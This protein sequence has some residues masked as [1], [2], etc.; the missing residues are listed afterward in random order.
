MNNMGGSRPWYK[1]GVVWVIIVVIVLVA[2]YFLFHGG[3]SSSTSNT[4]T[5]T[6]QTSGNTQTVST[7][8]QAG[9]VSVVGKLAC[10]PLKSGATPTA[11]QCLL[12]L[13]GNDGKFYALDTTK[14]ASTDNNITPDSTVVAVGTFTAS[15]PNNTESG[16][17]KYDG[18]LAVR[19]MAVNK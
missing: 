17:Y 5:N 7:T 13:Q 12:G 6:S 11:D 10:T 1:S 19:V 8:P 14:V 18:V 3:N 2:G 9:E 4:N 16:I 15:D